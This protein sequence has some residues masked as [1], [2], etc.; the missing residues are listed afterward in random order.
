MDPATFAYLVFSLGFFTFIMHYVTSDSHRSDQRRADEYR[1]F[2][3][4]LHDP[5]KRSLFRR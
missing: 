4:T 2:G 5:P 1:E 3:R